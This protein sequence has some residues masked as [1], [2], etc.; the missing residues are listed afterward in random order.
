MKR[1]PK[2]W[3]RWVFHNCVAHPLLPIA[4]FLDQYVEGNTSRSVADVIY[5][6]HDETVDTMPP[7]FIAGKYPNLV[8]KSGK[9][10]EK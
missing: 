6:L 2:W 3:V 9:L 8:Y 1:N 5:R 10:E 7:V 4:S